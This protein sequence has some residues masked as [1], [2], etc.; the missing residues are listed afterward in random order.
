M[1][2][3]ASFLFHFIHMYANEEVW[4]IV[5][6]GRENANVRTWM[7]RLHAYIISRDFLKEISSGNIFRSR[8]IFHNSHTSN[9]IYPSRLYMLDW[10]HFF[11]PLSALHVRPV[12]SCSRIPFSLHFIPFLEFLVCSVKYV[13]V[14]P[15]MVIPGLDINNRKGIRTGFFY[16]SIQVRQKKCTFFR[17]LSGL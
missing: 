15:S 17:I 7:F 1:N 16:V 8:S 4:R 11:V 14:Q 12:K 6:A 10:V 5:P 13:E 3:N 2:R 9:R